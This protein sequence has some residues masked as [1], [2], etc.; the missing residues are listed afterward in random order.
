MY[1][2]A[3][4]PADRRFNLL[5]FQLE[6]F[7]DLRTLGVPD[8]AEDAYAAYDQLREES[9]HGALIANVFAGGTVNTERCFLTG[10]SYLADYRRPSGSYVWYLDGQGYTTLG[11]HPHHQSF[12]N[13]VNIN[14]YLGFSDYWFYENHYEQA[15]DALPH[16]W[17]SDAVFFP[18]V[19]DQFLAHLAAGESVF[20]FNVSMQGHGPYADDSYLYPDRLWEGA[21]YSESTRCIV[22]NYLG[23]VRETSGFLLQT[24]EQLRACEEPIVLLVYGDHKPWLGDGN[25]AYQ[26]LGVDLDPSSEA[27]FF[28]HY[29]TEYL[30][31]ANDAALALLDGELSGDGPAISPGALM[32][33]L[34]ER[35]GWPGSAFMQLGREVYA[36]LPVINSNGY[37][38]ENGT[39]TRELS[40]A[41]A[42]LLHEYRCVQYYYHDLLIQQQK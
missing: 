13:R 25:A 36:A 7:S 30:I 4:I 14:R 1:E 32:G 28:N 24:A 11:S 37:Y 19:R 38:I 41:G 39:Y 42:A 2:D 29:A 21:G 15:I 20:S 26:E 18:A 5:V 6:A 3:A 16:P 23:S 10:C 9:L 8:I 31:W 17:F 35:L 40:P 22:N 12:Y 33:L 27:G 34:F